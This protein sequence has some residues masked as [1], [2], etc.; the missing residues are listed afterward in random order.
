MVWMHSS[1]TI[2]KCRYKDLG[3]V[4]LTVQ[5]PQAKAII[6]VMDLRLVGKMSLGD[7]QVD[8]QGARMLEESLVWLTLVDRCELGIMNIWCDFEYGHTS[9]PL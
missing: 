8:S 6:H 4:R 2:R 9:A 5:V 3:V 7:L 1:D